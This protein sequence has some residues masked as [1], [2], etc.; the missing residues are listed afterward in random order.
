MHAKRNM[1]GRVALS[2]I[3]LLLL[4]LLLLHSSFI[5]SFHLSSWDSPVVGL[6]DDFRN[7]LPLDLLVKREDAKIDVFKKA[8]DKG[9]GLLCDM[10]KSQEE[11]EEENGKSMESPSYLQQSGIEEREGW[12]IEGD[13]Q[14]SF[15]D[16][17]DEALAALGVSDD[18][19]HQS[20]IHTSGGII[21]TTNPGD[22][23]SG[24][25]GQ[26]TGAY[27]RNSFVVNPGV[28]IADVNYA[29]SAATGG[30]D[31]KM[32]VTH[33][34]KWSDATWMQWDR[35]CTEAG[36]DVNDLKYIIRSKIENHTT[37][38]IILKAILSRH[39]RNPRRNKKTIGT[40]R[41]KITFTAAKEKEE[42]PAILGSP[43]G[44][45]AAFML[46]NHKKRLGVK[47]IK[48]IDVFVPEGS[49]EVTETDV[50]EKHEE[51]NVMMLMY[52]VN[53]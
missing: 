35:V 2:S 39:N 42:F 19:H 8:L 17:L 53:P 33:V 32:T 40:W 51:W 50:E 30:N 6:D 22:L 27:F 44:A 38:E 21:S 1:P 36:G 29:V 34:K 31:G 37:L 11:L 23:A 45:G 3:S 26:D 24:T 47:T 52:I 10:G 9:K 43:N 14:P 41:N 16:Y 48:R 4:S 5:P 12:E 18:L 49:F 20:W 7:S 13:P 25:S 46:I 15:K 28:I